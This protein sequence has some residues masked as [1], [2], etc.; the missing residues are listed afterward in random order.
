VKRIIF[1]IIL[2]FIVFSFNIYSHENDVENNNVFFSSDLLKMLGQ[3]AGIIAFF[4]L[5]LTIF[6]GTT[7]RLFD[8]LFGL[9]KIL[10]FHKKFALFSFIVLFFHPSLLV[11]TN[12]IDGSG[13]FDFFMSNITYLP[14]LFGFTAFLI[15]I[16]IIMTSLFFKIINYFIWNITHHIS[17]I[18]FLFVLYHIYDF[19]ELSG[20]NPEIP[21]LNVFIILGLLFAVSG[22]IIRIILLFTKKKIISTVVENK[23]ETD[24]V[25]SII[26]KKPD[27]FKYNAGQF[28][29]ISFKMNGMRKPHP[30][31]ISSSPDEKYLVFSIK[32]LG[33]FTSK[34]R[35]VKKDTYIKIDGPYGVLRY[36]G[37]DSVFIAG[38]IGITPFRSILGDLKDL[39]GKEIYLIYG[40]RNKKDIV[41]Y[42]WLSDK[43]KK[44]QYKFINILSEEK[45]NG[46]DYGYIDNDLLKSKCN[47]NEDF[48]ICGPPLMVKKTMEVLRHNKVPYKKIFVEKF[49]W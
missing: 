38:G 6:I 21:L 29:F 43:Q 25:N 39:Y 7:S 1:I 31:T 24:N 11:V 48:Y 37:N 36:H 32:S 23:K 41:F 2:L 46:F 40:N 33:K 27:N 16:S 3:V 42:D 14:F 28:C 5:G 15:F 30:F 9:D 44:I 26:V 13:F 45:L 10:R 17:F 20:L 12:V 18:A 8:K 34:I 19:G 35:S 22:T 47:L 4:L 49:F